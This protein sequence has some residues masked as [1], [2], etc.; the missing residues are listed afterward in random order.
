MILSKIASLAFYLVIF[1]ITFLFAFLRK[2]TNKKIF[3][4]LSILVPAVALAAR[5]GVG[6]DSAAYI[7][8]F[9]DISSEPL[10]NS[11]ERIQT[12][13]MEPTAV[14]LIKI[15]HLFAFKYFAYFF[16]YSSL[17]FGL[18]YLFSRRL[19]KQNWWIIF[20][21]LVMIMTPYCINGMRQAAAVAVFSLLL[22]R[23][24]QKP[25][26]I[27]SNFLLFL[28]TFSVHFSAILLAP[29]ILAVLA[30]KRF[31]FRNCALFV[32]AFSLV[33]LIVFPKAITFMVDSGIMP[34]KY[35]AT[36]EVYEGSLANFDFVIF[37]ALSF[38][39]LL[40]RRHVNKEDIKLNDF[41][42]IAVTCN[43]FYAGLG[44]FSAYIGRMSDYFW[45]MA[46]FSLWLG[47]DRFRDNDSFKRVLFV[48]SLVCYF[49]IVYFVM[50]NSEILPFRFLS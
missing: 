8:M 30:L 24:F 27:V 28:L 16:A 11:L 45:P 48:A 25:R 13:S 14:F 34:Y 4:F 20:G 2:R 37:F 9:D 50:G 38:L 17:T 36:L 12:F 1:A 7:T 18:L 32:V 5:F 41:A 42:T 35:A 26:E 22:I 40:T 23:V 46:V 43:L 10:K 29:V 31:R 47:F 15:L 49:V 39:L 3:G 19:D 21:S 44:F 6:T 33:S